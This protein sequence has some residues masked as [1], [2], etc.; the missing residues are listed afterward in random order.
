[1]LC[2]QLLVEAVCVYDGES[3]LTVMDSELGP[4]PFHVSVHGLGPDTAHPSCGQAPLIPTLGPH[5]LALCWGKG[6]GGGFVFT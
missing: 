6:E 1:M 3:G 4:V 5:S 2:K